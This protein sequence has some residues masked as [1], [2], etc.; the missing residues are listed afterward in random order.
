MKITCWLAVTENGGVKSRKNKPDVRANE[1]P[2]RLDL[3]IPDE[4]FQRPVLQANVKVPKESYMQQPITAEVADNIEDIIRQKT[5]L[6]FSVTVN[7]REE[8]DDGKV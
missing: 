1:I 4:L 8:E 3:D 6:E 5:G 7:H 2:I